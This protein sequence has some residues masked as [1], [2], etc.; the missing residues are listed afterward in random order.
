MGCGTNL[1]LLDRIHCV[2]DTMAGAIIVCVRAFLVRC[3]EQAHTSQTMCLQQR[4]RHECHLPLAAC[5]TERQRT[6]E[7]KK[8]EDIHEARENKKK[9]ENGKIEGNMQNR[10]Q[11]F[12]LA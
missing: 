8:E 6:E 9:S 3:R 4:Q 10:Q 5:Q 11:T 12:E 2:V 7:K 1:S